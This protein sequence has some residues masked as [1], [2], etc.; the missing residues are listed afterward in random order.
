[1]EEKKIN[2]G[3]A[4]NII[5]L[6]VRGQIIPIHTD[7]FIFDYSE[8]LKSELKSNNRNYPIYLDIAPA[9]FHSIVSYF[10]ILSDFGKRKDLVI[11]DNI[12]LLFI[13]EFTN[14]PLILSTFVYLEMSLQFIK[15]FNK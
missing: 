1:M 5:Q 9:A 8:R 4:I 10:K 12:R 2:K 3:T 11:L 14:N 13:E 7:N 15:M 6:N